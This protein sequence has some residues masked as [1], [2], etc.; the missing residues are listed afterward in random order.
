V[1]LALATVIS[2]GLTVKHYSA[3]AGKPT[4]TANK[5]LL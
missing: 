2:S 4:P 3:G 1:K 5:T